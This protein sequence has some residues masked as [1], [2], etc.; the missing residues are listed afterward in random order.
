MSCSSRSSGRTSTIF[1][2]AQDVDR[3]NDRLFALG[4]CQLYSAISYGLSDFLGFVVFPGMTK[5]DDVAPSTLLLGALQ[6]S[7]DRE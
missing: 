1:P 3:S 4:Y 5:L 6:A 7:V 2:R